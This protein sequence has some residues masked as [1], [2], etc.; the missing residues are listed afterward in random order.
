MNKKKALIIDD[1]RGDIELLKVY[2]L[3][4]S[5][6]YEVFWAS[7]GEQGLSIT[8]SNELDIIFLDINLPGLDG[9]EVCQ[10]LKA[11]TSKNVHLIM[12]TG[13]KDPN[14]RALAK[15]YGADGFCSKNVKDIIETFMFYFK[16]KS[17]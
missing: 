15:Q 4:H 1:N 8:E 5:L 3:E 13:S 10:Q 6:D 16:N 11:S 7:S 12:M 2:F 9:Y 17:K 14:A